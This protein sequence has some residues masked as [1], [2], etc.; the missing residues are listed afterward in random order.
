MHLIVTLKRFSFDT[1]SNSRSKIM[2]SVRIPSTLCLP[3][4][5]AIELNAIDV[6]S[7]TAVDHGHYYT[8]ARHSSETQLSSSSSS[9]SSSLSSLSSSWVQ[10]NDSNVDYVST[11]QLDRFWTEFPLDTPYMLFYKRRQQAVPFAAPENELQV[12]L[13]VEQW[14]AALLKRV[15][16]DNEQWLIEKNT[17]DESAANNKRQPP[18]WL[19]NPRNNFPTRR[20]PY[21]DKDEF[22]GSDGWN[23][24]GGSRAVF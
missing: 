10:F 2:R 4:G 13:A 5:V 19:R 21:D 11:D 22:G 15:Q 3:N 1:R 17:D 20:P 12:P 14:P 24:M 16:A 23:P 8:V 7:G 9:S 6:H 18:S